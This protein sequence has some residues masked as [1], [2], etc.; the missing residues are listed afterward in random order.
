VTNA[1][2]SI[3]GSGA[4]LN[5]TVNANNSS[6]VVTFEY[7]LTASYGS[8]AT[9]VQSP[10][11]GT[12]S[13][14][15]NVAVTGLAGNTTYH[16]RAKGVNAGGT[17][18]GSD[19]TFTTSAVPPVVTTTAATSVTTTGATLNGTV[20]ANNASTTVIFEYG[21]TTGYGSTVTAVQ[22]PVSGG[23]ATAVNAAITGL[24]PNTLYHFRAVG[25]NSGGTTNGNDMTFTTSAA[26]PTVT[27]N[28]ATGVFANTATLNGTVN[29]NN[30]AT[31]VSFE[32]GLTTSYGSSIA[33]TPSSVSGTTATAVLA[34]LTGLIMNTTYHFRCVG[35]NAGGTVYGGDMTFLTCPT[36][37]PAGPVS[38]PASVCPAS[39]GVVYTIPPVTN[40]TGYVWSVPADAV[41]TAGNNTTSITV[42]FGSA[43]G[44]VSVYG[45]GTCYTGAPATLAVTVNPAP[46][47]TIAGE[48]EL[49]ANTDGVVYNTEAGFNS[50]NW[51]VSL[52]GIITAGQHS[53]QVTVNWGAAGTR[54]IWV[55]YA[56]QYGCSAIQPTQMTVSL[57]NRP[58]PI[59]SGENELCAGTNGVA[60]NTQPDYTGY[61]WTVSSGGTITAGQG[62]DAIT[63]NWTG[64]GA[65][66]VS[67]TFESAAGCQAL[68]PTVYEV[69]VTPKPANAG[70][71]TGTNPV[72]SGAEGVVYSVAPIADAVT[73]NWT[74]PTGAV[75]VSGANTSAITVNFANNA[76]PGIIKVYGSND[77]GSGNA[78]PN[79]NLVVNATPAAP[80]I[81]QVLDTLISSAP[82]GNQWYLDGTEIA[83]ATDQQYVMTENGTYTCVVTL[84]GCSSAVSNA[85]TVLNVSVDEFGFGRT[86]EVYPNPSN[87]AFDVKARSAKAMVCTLEVYTSQGKLLL[88]QENLLIDGAI[89]RHIDLKGSP[90]GTYLVVLHNRDNSVSRRVIITR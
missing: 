47:P 40:A 41:I 59:I 19:L 70:P 65:Q 21:L 29:A 28:A 69:N 32:Y 86:M 43:S 9:A 23:T 50:Y 14:A 44:N 45:T 52:G 4:T 16:F 17:T 22:S 82:A 89:T 58:V 73:Y 63:V 33:A 71:V 88:K 90:E 80:V 42:T 61:N 30:A 34:N 31:T 11:S 84:N 87:G 54:F 10:V 5:G 15:V 6:T 74:V 85:I 48:S 72:C 8:T 67:V 25:T 60:Y 1:A 77:C 53:N 35:V 79:F 55:N 39:A 13:T 75:I 51:S 66:T 76:A 57:L 26:P 7:G 3:T 64:G 56:N 62:T 81:T 36:V 18:Y 49:C 68:V 24:T 46:S 20:N 37:G 83:G 27:T 12:S 78:S 38:G 2:T